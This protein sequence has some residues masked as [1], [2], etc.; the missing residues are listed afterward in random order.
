MSLSDTIQEIVAAYPEVPAFEDMNE[1]HQRR[2]IA[3]YILH[4]E[5]IVAD[6]LA[7]IPAGTLARQRAS[8]AVCGECDRTILAQ[9]IGEA[10]YPSAMLADLVQ[11]ELDVRYATEDAA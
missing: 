1:A 8:I 3:A 5:T 2:L 4:D 7:D 6:I 9:T 10:V 11:H